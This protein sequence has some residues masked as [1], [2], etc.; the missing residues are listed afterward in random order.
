[1]TNVTNLIVIGV[2]MA[3]NTAAQK[4]ASAGWSVAVIDELPYG[5]TCVL[6]GCDPKKML[7][8]GAEFIDAARLMGQGN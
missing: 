7:R 8:R 6:R 5:G 3:A 4:C 2:G 1:M